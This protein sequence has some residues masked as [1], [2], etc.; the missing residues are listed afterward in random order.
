MRDYTHETRLGVFNPRTY[1]AGGCHV[2]PPPHRVFFF[3]F[4]LDDKTSAPDIFPLLSSLA[5]ILRQVQ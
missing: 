4:F 3:S 5:H 2:P 1:E